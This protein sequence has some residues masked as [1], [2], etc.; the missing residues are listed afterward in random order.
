MVVTRK[1]KKLSIS[2]GTKNQTLPYGFKTLLICT[3][4]IW[5]GI[6]KPVLWPYVLLATAKKCNEQRS[7]QR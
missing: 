3:K 6:L 4:N 5:S 1:E 2:H 7:Q